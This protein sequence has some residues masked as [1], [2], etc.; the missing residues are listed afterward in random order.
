MTS[1]VAGPA[2]LVEREGGC[3]FAGEDTVAGGGE[4]AWPLPAPPLHATFLLVD[5]LWFQGLPS[6][7]EFFPKSRKRAEATSESLYQPGV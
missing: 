6:A 4:G 5:S 7:P 3:L 1:R 2:S